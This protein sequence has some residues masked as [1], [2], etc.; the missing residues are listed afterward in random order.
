[1]SV[2]ISVVLLGAI[3]LSPLDIHFYSINLTSFFSL[4]AEWKYLTIGL[5]MVILAMVWR[6][7]KGKKSE[8]HFILES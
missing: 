3:Y 5:V 7:P 1:M 2:L 8:K 4:F 6:G